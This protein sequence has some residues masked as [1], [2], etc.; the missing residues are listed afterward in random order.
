MSRNVVPA[1]GLLL[2]GLLLAMDA[3]GFLGRKSK[4]KQEESPPPPVPVAEERAPVKND[5]PKGMISI[6]VTNVLGKYLPSRV[7]LHSPEG[8]PLV[9][10]VPKGQL[11]AQAPV[12]A[13]EAHL[14]IYDW[15][16]PLM[17]TAKPI[18]VREG[19]TAY[20]LFNQDFG[21]VGSRTLWDFDQD[22]DL[23]IDAAEK[24]YGSDPAN[25]TS[26]PGAQPLSFELSSFGEDLKWY[27]GDLHVRSAY[28]GGEETVKD[29]IKRAEKTGL[30][31]LA[32]T[33]RNSLESISDPG[34]SSDKL[35]LVPAMEWGTDERG[36]ALIY[37]PL[38]VPTPASLCGTLMD[39]Q[40]VLQR[41]QAQGGVFAIAHPCFQ[42]SPWQWGLGYVNA[43]EVWCRDWRGMPGM[44]L[45]NLNQ[46]HHRRDPK[47]GKL[48]YSIAQAA[49]TEGL[50]AND[51]ANMFWDLEL[52]H[53][54]KASVIGGS[55][56]SSSKVPM[57]QPLT[58]VLAPEKSLAGIIDG[59]RRGYTYVSSGLDGPTLHFFADVK[60]DGK[61]DVMLGEAIPLNV[62]TT[63]HILVK[64]GDGKK[65]QL[66][67]DGKPLLTK[68]IEGS[69]FYMKVPYTPRERSAFY[70]RVTDTPD[71][72]GF[73][74]VDV[75]AISSPI[76][77]LDIMFLDEEQIDQDKGLEQFWVKLESKSEYTLKAERNELGEPMVR[78]SGFIPPF[79]VP[80]EGEGNIPVGPNDRF[81]QPEFE[82]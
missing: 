41:V 54:L 8:A 53:G 78:S 77:A 74:Y 72:P 63:F 18:E 64:G 43:V 30:D 36:Y 51:Q 29:L 80:R 24:E 17:V 65:C 21:V 10:N 66:M 2:I 55:V 16:I 47:S 9:F 48:T 61:M 56:S 50:S 58:Y 73:G 14:Y 44:M 12:G 34:Y 15:N 13:Y 38:T 70:V 68:I 4:K 40:G 75:D 67:L 19:Q 31:F 1:L 76:Y 59:L 60:S 20:I 28:G 82:F 62:E 45:K 7:E 71:K 79:L 35:V 46:E 42:T 52:R 3:E 11:E 39:A 6:D 22:Y 25:P 33:D 57:G 27:R 5:G 37:C 23:V 81:I 69:T 26:F 49:A 32:I